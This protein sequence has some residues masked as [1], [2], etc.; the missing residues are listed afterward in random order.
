MENEIPTLCAWAG[1]PE[2]LQ[3]MVRRFYERVPLDP[4][5]APVFATM[6]PHHAE[7]VAAFVI[8]VFGGPKSYTTSGG[9]HAHMIG[10]H[11]GRHLT[12]HLRKRWIAL[13]L[14]PRT[15]WACRAIRNFA[16]HSSDI[17]SGAHDS[18]SKIRRTAWRFR[19]TT[20][21][22]LCGAGDLPAVH[23]GVT[24]IYSIRVRRDTSQHGR[25]DRLDRN[26]FGS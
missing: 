5:L 24:R 16:R 26:P 1:G 14:I 11:L 8:E 23:G 19:P 17:W 22:C 15:K 18:R 2:N 12:D 25:V 3:A 13:M 10:R 21:R 7:H 20:R 9:S 4:D 6:N